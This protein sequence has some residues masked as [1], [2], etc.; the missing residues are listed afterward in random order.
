MHFDKSLRF[1]AV[2]RILYSQIEG[3]HIIE[4]Q[5][6]NNDSYEASAVEISEG[7]LK[8]VGYL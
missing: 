6:D 2:R 4:F 8:C 5:I 7:K 1:N 3:K